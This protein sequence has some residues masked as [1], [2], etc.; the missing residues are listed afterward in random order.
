LR[1]DKVMLVFNKDWREI[2]RNKEV[3]V[4]IIIVPLIFSIVLPLIFSTIPS[5]QSNIGGQVP[6]PLPDYARAEIRGMEGSQVIQYIM[7][8]YILAP[9][10]LIIPL[11][12]SSVIAADSFAGEKERKTIEALLATPI[13]DSELFIGKVLVSLI[14]SMMVTLLAFAIYSAIVDVSMFTAIGRGLLLPNIA[15]ALTIFL[16]SPALA[17]ASISLT[18]MISARV[19]GFREA[20]QISSVLLLPILGLVFSQITGIAFFGPTIILSLTAVLA[21]VDVIIFRVSIKVF[22]REKILQRLT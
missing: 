14:P 15:W 8:V 20:Q 11:M 13:S 2:R 6:F 9:I 1:I 10:F 5:G 7:L 22:G 21:A 4:P 19:R 12:A 16:L 18:V 17:M 3:M